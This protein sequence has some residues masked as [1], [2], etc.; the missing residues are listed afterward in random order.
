[1]SDVT[2]NR[3]TL[4]GYTALRSWGGK[5]VKRDVAGQ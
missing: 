5:D 4:L 1:M 3:E 2:E